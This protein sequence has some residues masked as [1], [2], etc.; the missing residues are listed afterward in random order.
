MTSRIV[1]LNCGIGNIGSIQNMLRKLG[2]T[3]EHSDDPAVIGAA[4]RLILPGVG[5]YDHGVTQLRASGMMDAIRARVV[6][7]IPL[8]GIC[9]GMQLLLE[10]SEEGTL[11]GFGFIGGHCRRFPAHATRKVPHM[12]WNQVEPVDRTTLFAGEES[13]FRFYFVHSYRALCTDDADVLGWTEYGDR[14]ASAV[15]R[16]NVYGVQFHPEKSHRFGL[17]VLRNF[18][19]LESPC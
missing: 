17:Q 1:I 19:A 13:E 4:S 16:D 12:G 11:P 15:R 3:G 9:L 18:I 5:A 10:G 7:G 14:F 6:E 8:L 2:A